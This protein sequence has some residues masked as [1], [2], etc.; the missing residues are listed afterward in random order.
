MRLAF[1]VAWASLLMGSTVAAAE[2]PLAQDLPAPRPMADAEKDA[3]QKVKPAS[4]TKDA[5]KS[6]EE[7]APKV[8]ETDDLLTP[9]YS[10]F[11]DPRTF[12]WTQHRLP[13][14]DKPCVEMA[15]QLHMC[16]KDHRCMREKLID[17][18]LHWPCPGR[19]IFGKCC[20]EEP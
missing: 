20:P 16:L 13:P 1:L 2:P 15:C 5:E 10:S 3:R 6:P 7:A 11:M 12:A 17:W 4:P 19:L 8:K 18:V 9:A 14:A